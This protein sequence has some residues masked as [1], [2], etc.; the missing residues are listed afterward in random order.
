M[1]VKSK[2][3]TVGTTI[4]TTMSALA[5]Q[6]GAIHLSQ[7]FPD[8]DPPTELLEACSKAM[9][10]GHNQYAPMAGLLALREQLALTAEKRYGGR[11]DPE[12]EITVVPGATEALFCAINAL[13]HHGD[14]VIMLD[15]A[16]DSYQPAVE[17]AGGQAIRVPLLSPEFKLD[18]QALADAISP[19]TRML[20]INSPNNPSCSLLSQQDLEQLAELLRDTNI[21]LLSDEVYEYLVYDGKTH[22]SVLGNAELRQR[23]LAVFSFGKSFHATGWKTGYCIAPPEL[24]A[25]LRKVHQYVTFVANTPVQYALADFYASNNNHLAGLANF[26]QAKRDRFC[27]ALSTS[28][29]KFTPSAGTYF[30]LVDYSNISELEDLD[31]C[32]WLTREVGVAAIPLSPFY[33]HPPAQRLARFCFAKQDHTLDLAAEKLCQL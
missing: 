14:E 24:T 11:V 10:Q 4:F 18:W 33:Q 6:H 1:L 25:E 20:I 23:S 32:Q 21:I 9:L 22:A 7:G 31:F 30:Q 28:S 29:F 19:R 3:P 12:Q 2:L 17:L 26:Y 13:V 5:Q 16:Y 27:Q 8:Y 15:P